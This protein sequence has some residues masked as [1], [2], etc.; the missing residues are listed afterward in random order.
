MKPTDQAQKRIRRI[1]YRLGLAA[2]F[3]R[4]EPC[5]RSRNYRRHVKRD[6]SKARRRLDRAV[7]RAEER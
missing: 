7:E 5:A 4:T 1:D 6:L 3:T 2:M